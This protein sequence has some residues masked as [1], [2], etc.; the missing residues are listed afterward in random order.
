[1]WVLQYIPCH[2]MFEDTTDRRGL[3]VNWESQ[4]EGQTNKTKEKTSNNLQS[5]PQKTKTHKKR[6]YTQVFWKGRQFLHHQ[7]HQSCV[8]K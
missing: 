3:G 7:W 5:T 8:V 4:F 1:M 2:E 6:R